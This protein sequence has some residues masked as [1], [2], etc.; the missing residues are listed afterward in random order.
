MQIPKILGEL[1]WIH[2]NTDILTI[3]FITYIREEEPWDIG[4]ISSMVK[5]N[6]NCI[7]I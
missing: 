3:L 2:T 7:H 4:P 1:T 5:K 6:E